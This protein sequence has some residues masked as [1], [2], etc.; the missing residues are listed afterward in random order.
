MNIHSSWWST[1]LILPRFLQILFPFLE[2][3][4]LLLVWQITP[5][6]NNRSQMSAQ[7]VISN[8]EPHLVPASHGLWS[9]ELVV[10]VTRAGL[11]WSTDAGHGPGPRLWTEHPV[12]LLGASSARIKHFLKLFH[13]I[14]GITWFGFVSQLQANFTNLTWISDPNCCS[15]FANSDFGKTGP[16]AL[17]VEFLDE[18]ASVVVD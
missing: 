5:D 16:N 6:C 10:A 2:T 4:L 9:L 15:F 7:A 3:T 12:R 17:S 11:P 14:L 18:D 13:F 8:T 1:E